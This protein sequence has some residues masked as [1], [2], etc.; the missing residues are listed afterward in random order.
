MPEMRLN[1]VTRDWIIIAT[2]R[3]KRPADFRRFEDRAFCPPYVDTCPFCAGNESK[4]AEELFRTTDDGAWKIRVVAN[5]YPAVAVSG[6]KKRITD[7]TRRMVSGVGRHEVIIESPVHNVSP[8]LLDLKYVED[9]VRCY[10]DRFVEAYRDPR[11]D[12]VIIFKNHGAGSGTSVDHPHSQ[13]IGIPVVP[14]KFRD[15]VLAAMHY[16]DDTGE[17]MIC[18]I[19][20]MEIKDGARVVIDTGDFLTFVPY[21]AI[22][23]FHLWIIPKRH[24]ATFSDITEEE[25][26]GLAR[27]L[28][29]LLLKYHIG[30]EDPD[31]NF[32]IRSSRPA[33]AGNPYSHW[34]LSVIARISTTAG[35]EL[36]SGIYY[37]T[38]V[39]EEIAPFLRAIKV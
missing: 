5:K 7:G 28:K 18:D 24:T 38:G 30:L 25:I 39:P 23:P 12:H 31:Y 22:S 21:A 34:Y 11:V 8:A 1:L 15:R 4:S 19:I 17:C 27:H 26:N 33:D 36:G 6:E 10:R 14:M 3:A 16:F 32:V 9:I 37:N 13:L 2:E 35:F 29:A 20:K